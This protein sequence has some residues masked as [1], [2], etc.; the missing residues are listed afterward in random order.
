MRRAVIEEK[1][2]E[3]RA[4]TTKHETLKTL[5]ELLIRSRQTR[6]N[7]SIQEELLSGEKDS[8]AVVEKK[9]REGKLSYLDFDKGVNSLYSA[10]ESYVTT[11]FELKTIEAQFEFHQGGVS[12]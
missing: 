2:T 4:E 1:N 10:Q 12:P 11:Y 5:E 8:F 9:Y 3:S 6:E 7:F